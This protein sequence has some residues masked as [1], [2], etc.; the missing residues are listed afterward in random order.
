MCVAQLSRML[1]NQCDGLEEAGSA[2]LMEGETDI[3]LHLIF[4]KFV[5]SWYILLTDSLRFH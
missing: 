4:S 1:F 3:T 2:G 5:D